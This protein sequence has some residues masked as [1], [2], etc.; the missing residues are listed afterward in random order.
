MFLQWQHRREAAAVARAGA[1]LRTWGYIA[2]RLIIIAIMLTV[3]VPLF[4][5]LSPRSVSH[6]R[7]KFLDE[8]GPAD[9]DRNA[10]VYLLYELNKRQKH[11]YF[12]VDFEVFKVNAL[13]STEQEECAREPGAKGL[14]YADLL[15]EGKPFIGISSEQIVGNYFWQNRA[16]VSVL[17]TYNRKYYE[18][19]STYDFL[20]YATLI[21]STLIHL[22]THCT[23][24][25]DAFKRSSVSYGGLFQF[26]PQRTSIKAVILAAHF[27][28]REEALLLNC[29]GAEYMQTM[30]ALLTLD[31]LHKE[32]VLQNLKT[33]FGVTK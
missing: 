27:N 22:N 13:R 21:Q 30:S 24:L 8:P 29:F 5:Y 11:W 4:V 17:S 14:C 18:P 26:L 12:E 25:P 10:F 33:V 1:A 19:L 3:V 20:V 28:P 15:A 16:N 7:I 9:F 2:P 32:P 31:W 23:N 6:I